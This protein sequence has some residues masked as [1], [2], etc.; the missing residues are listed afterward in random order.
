M[1]HCVHPSD[2]AP[3]LMLGHD[4]ELGDDIELGAWVVIHSGTVVGDG[5]VIQDGAV[6]GKRAR[7]GAKSTA[8]RGS[9]GAPAS[10]AGCRGVQPVQ[11]ST[12]ARSLPRTRS[13]ATRPR[14]ASAA[15]S[16]PVR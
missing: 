7:L 10:G 1:K 15:M 3:G 14:S 12:P 4:T 8:P 11:W 13:L 16:V 9:L 6:L 5:C 2:L